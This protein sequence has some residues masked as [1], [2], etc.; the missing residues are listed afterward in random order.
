MCGDNV[1]QAL[2]RIRISTMLVDAGYDS[3]GNRSF[4]RDEYGN[5]KVIPAK[6]GRLTKNPACAVKQATFADETIKVNAEIYA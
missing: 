3:K 2:T 5:R 4:A 6:H 1:K